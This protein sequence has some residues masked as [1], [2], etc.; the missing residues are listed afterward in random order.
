MRNF[1]LGLLGLLVLGL[2]AYFCFTDKSAVIKDKL[3]QNAQ[4]VYTHEGMDWVKT[5]LE[6]EGLDL[7]RV[8]RLEGEA[9]SLAL[10]SKA[11]EMAH[12]VPGIASVVDNLKLAQSAIGTSPVVTEPVVEEHLEAASIKTEAIEAEEK[13][14]TTTV[15]DDVLTAKKEEN[16]SSTL[17]LTTPQTEQKEVSSVEKNSSKTAEKVI[18]HAPQIASAKEV[19]TPKAAVS[20]KVEVQK[21]SP[22]LKDASIKCQYLIENVMTQKKIHFKLAKATIKPDS[23]A[24]LDRIVRIA[25]E[26]DDVKIVISGYTDSKGSKK[27]NKWLSQQRANAVKKYLVDAGVDKKH[28]KAVGYGEENPIADNTKVSGRAQNRRIEFHIQGVAK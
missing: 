6:G 8:L 11:V 1:W 9:P 10:K 23:Y 4:A 27:Y 16:I 21:H 26:C 18:E 5:D 19:T 3:L 20:K 14:E 15:L 24:L 13:N 12:T 2:L 22:E 25:T 7:K 17:P 28:L